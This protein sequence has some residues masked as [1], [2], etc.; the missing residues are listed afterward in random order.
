MLETT[1]SKSTQVAELLAAS[2]VINELIK[3]CH[4]PGTLEEQRQKRE[5]L[6]NIAMS[7]FNPIEE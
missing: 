1:L 6:A 4:K 5:L 7:A 3:E 2:I